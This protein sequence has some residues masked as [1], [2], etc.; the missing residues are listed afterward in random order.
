MGSVQAGDPWHVSA[1]GWL[2]F[3]EGWIAEAVVLFR[4]TQPGF[5]PRT[6]NLV[7]VSFLGLGLSTLQGSSCVQRAA[8]CGQ[9]SVREG[10]LL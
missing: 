2:A 9:D 4:A 3:S 8:V 6:T 5:N 1:V 7:L 10:S